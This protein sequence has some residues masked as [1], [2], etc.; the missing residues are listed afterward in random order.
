MVLVV[1]NKLSKQRPALDGNDAV[2][3]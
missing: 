3:Q 2:I 1:I